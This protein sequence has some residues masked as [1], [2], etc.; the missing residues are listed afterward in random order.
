MGFEL[1]EPR[2][3]L[4]VPLVCQLLSAK[5]YDNIVVEDAL[6]LAERRI[7]DVLR[8]IEA[9]FRAAGRTAFPHRRPHRALP[10]RYTGAAN[11]FNAFLTHKGFDVPS[12]DS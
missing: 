3:E 4:D 7:V 1:S 12:M 11:L 9:D 6:D 5:D 2:A 8:E 10:R